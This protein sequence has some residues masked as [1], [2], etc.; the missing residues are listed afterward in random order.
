MN[1]ELLPRGGGE[2]RGRYQSLSEKRKPNSYRGRAKKI[3]GVNNKQQKHED[4]QTQKNKLVEDRGEG[5]QMVKKSN[6]NTLS[7][8]VLQKN[9]NA[10][11]NNEG[12][13]MVK[14]NH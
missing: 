6:N 4:H 11:K 14:Q 10:I 2:E 7:S 13:Q 5:K 12:K 8:A 3:G 9:L 1:S